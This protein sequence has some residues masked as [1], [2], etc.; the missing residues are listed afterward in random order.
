MSAAGEVDCLLRSR[1]RVS[2]TAINM[3]SP[4]TV[5]SPIYLLQS[6][7]E[8]WRCHTPQ[9]VVALAT[10]RLR[11]DDV[12]TLDAAPNSEEEPFLLSD[13]VELPPELV[14]TQ[15]VKPGSRSAAA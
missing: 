1:N 10:H 7:E 5:G 8:C 3:E 13:I 2:L 4:I 14:G 11:D 12:D 6:T 9:V 15:A